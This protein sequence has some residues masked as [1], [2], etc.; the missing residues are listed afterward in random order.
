[1]TSALARE[2][3]QLLAT[4]PGFTIDKNG[5][6][7]AEGYV[8][9]GQLK[10][11]DHALA[12]FSQPTNATELAALA[13]AVEAKLGEISNYLEEGS[14]LGGWRDGESVVLDLV[15]V[16]RNRREA[17]QL[18]KARGQLAYGEIT[19]YQYAKEWRAN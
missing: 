13:D 1:M 2:A 15:T 6:P 16:T 12:I 19:S 5:E 18:A 9:G 11:E 17:A 7:L 8:I 4:Q 14:Y 3:A 10:R